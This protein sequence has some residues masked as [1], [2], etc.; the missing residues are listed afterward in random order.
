MDHDTHSPSGDLNVRSSARVCGVPSLSSNMLILLQQKSA[1][2]R[3]NM[4]EAN[5]MRKS[6]RKSKICCSLLEAP[7]VAPQARL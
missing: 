2:I 3:K 7:S 1:K 4:V 6:G 5:S